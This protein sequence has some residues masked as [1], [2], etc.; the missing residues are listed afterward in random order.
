MPF[1]Q[2]LQR[3]WLY[4]INRESWRHKKWKYIGLY[5]LKHFYALKINHIKLW[6]FFLPVLTCLS[7]AHSATMYKA[8]LKCSIWNHIVYI[9]VFHT[10]KYALN[11]FPQYNHI[12]HRNVKYIWIFTFRIWYHSHTSAISFLTYILAQ[13]TAGEE[14]LIKM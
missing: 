8:K 13:Y 3:R 12:L 7:L 2:I 4:W 14:F 6:L 1:C 9:T 11:I 10:F 5:T